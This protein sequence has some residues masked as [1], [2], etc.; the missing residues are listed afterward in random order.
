MAGAK[1]KAAADQ[2]DP[3]GRRVLRN[4]LIAFMHREITNRSLE[5]VYG[6]Y[7]FQRKLADRS[8]RAIAEFTYNLS[9][10]FVEHTI[11]LGAPMQ[12]DAVRPL[13]QAQAFLQTDLQIPREACKLPRSLGTPWP[14]ET[15]EQRSQYEHLMGERVAEPGP[16]DVKYQ[17]LARLRLRSAMRVMFSWPM[18]PVVL[19]VAF[20]LALWILLVLICVLAGG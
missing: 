20:G 5:K 18:L 16:L 15:V 6:Q 3:E 4:A 12:E 7:A 8:L 10:D 17:E 13:D 11:G 1:S 14:F 9:D 2:V 19:L